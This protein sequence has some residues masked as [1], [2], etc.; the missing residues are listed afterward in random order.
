[1]IKKKTGLFVLFP[2]SIHDD[3]NDK[4]ISRHIKIIKVRELY[5][6]LQ[7]AYIC[8]LQVQIIYF[9]PKNV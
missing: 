5:R 9:R 7:F 8:L 6:E 3:D 1:M 4:K 2:N